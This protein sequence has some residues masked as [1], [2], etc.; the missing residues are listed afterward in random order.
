MRVRTGGR[1]REVKGGG[2]PVACDILAGFTPGKGST[3][4]WTDFHTDLDRF[5]TDF[6]HSRSHL[7]SFVASGVVR[8]IR[9]GPWTK[10]RPTGPV[11]DQFSY[12]FWTSFSRRACP[13]SFSV[14][15]GHIALRTK[16]YGGKVLVKLW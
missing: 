1:V 12:R 4:R 5:R 9:L 14:T 8:P 2:G 10:I 16:R 11:L 3:E 13:R 7:V 15:F 6:F